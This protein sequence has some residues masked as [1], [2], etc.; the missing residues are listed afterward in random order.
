MTTF[1][2]P[3]D[4]ELTLPPGEQVIATR[5]DFHRFAELGW[6]E[7]RT[8][9]KIIRTLEALGLEVAYGR[10]VVDG[11]S[12]LGLPPDSKLDVEWRRALDQGADPALESALAGGFTGVVATLSTGRPGPILACRFDIDANSVQEAE[13]TEH[14]PSREGFASV[15]PGVHHNCGHD[16]HTAIGLTLARL[17][18]EDYAHLGG[19]IRLIFQPAEEGLRGGRAMVAAGVLDDVD[20]LIGAHIGVQA[21][22]TG[23]VIAGYDRLLDSNK[24]DVHFSGRNAHAGISP[25]LGNNALL[26][27]VVATQNLLAISRHG[28]GETRV[29]VGVLQG[30]EARNSIPAHAILKGEVRG[31]DR[32]VGRYLMQRADDIIA[33]AAGMHRVEVAIEEVGRSEGADSSLALRETVQQL[34][35][36]V[37]GVNQVVTSAEFKASDDVAAM[38]QTV[39]S[40]GGQAVYM[41]LG[42]A[43]SGPHHSP[44]FD[45]DEACLGLGVHLFDKVIRST[46]GAST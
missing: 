38:M 33:N 10:D 41:G 11:P 20:H 3:L 30:G 1:Q 34:A 26:A 9:S 18:V 39:Q 13:G 14:R 12:R 37:P 17:L 22:E 45:F 4:V 23:T 28:A 44:D 46:L 31:E 42:A 2:H 16:G 15:N 24:F 35:R 8:T 19:E 32:E 25:E 7:F 36:E 21:R 5:R 43:L 29:N 6:C 40:N 27:A